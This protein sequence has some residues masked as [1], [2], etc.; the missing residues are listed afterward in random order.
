MVAVVVVATAEMTSAKIGSKTAPHSNAGVHGHLLVAAEAEAE[1]EEAGL[2]MRAFFE[3][4][5]AMLAL[6]HAPLGV[7]IDGM[8]MARPPREPTCRFALGQGHGSVKGCQT[9]G[10][11]VWG[12]EACGTILGTGATEAMCD[13]TPTTSGATWILAEICT[14][15]SMMGMAVRACWTRATPIFTQPALFIPLARK[16][17]SA[18]EWTW[19]G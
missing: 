6:V 9:R 16:C 3:T 14:R 17:A 18:N 8:A 7:E 11:R 12:K 2:R 13:G 19:G 4:E 10:R 15:R 1:A 5:V